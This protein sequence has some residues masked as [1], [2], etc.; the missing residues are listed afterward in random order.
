MGVAAAAHPRRR[1][2]AGPAPRRRRPRR[3]PARPARGHHHAHRLRRRAEI[4]VADDG[5]G[6]PEA[7]R[8][9]VFERF[10]RLDAD[11]SRQRGGAGLGL[12]IA[13][14]LVAVHGGTL[15]VEPEADGGARFRVTLPRASDDGP[16]P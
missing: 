11:R 1:V 15:T 6:I 2:R 10:A 12:P 14:E 3:P 16:A 4:V 9:R 7:D 8:E 5:P 13:R